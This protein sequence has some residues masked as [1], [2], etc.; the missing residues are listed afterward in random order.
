MTKA[1]EAFEKIQRLFALSDA[2]NGTRS[3]SELLQLVADSIADILPADRV[4]LIAFDR[5]SE[6]VTHFMRAG[7]G[8]EKINTSV[9]YAELLT[10][11][12]G[13]VLREGKA[14]LSPKSG[15]DPRE[16]ADVIKRRRETGCG[17]ILV[18]PL[19]HLDVNIGTITAINN[20]DQD[21]FT[22]TDRDML[23]LFADYSATVIDHAR[24]LLEVRQARISAEETSA[25]MKEYLEEKELILKEVHHRI[26]NN[27]TTIYGL[28]TMQA[29]TLTNSEAAAAL[30]DAASRVQSMMVLYNKLYE[31]PNFT[32]ISLREYIPALV[33]EIVANFPNSS[34]IRVEKDI[35]DFVLDVRRVQPLG[36]ILNEL[37]TNIMKYAFS[38]RT[39][40]RIS[41]SA[42]CM[43]GH[44]TIGVRDN[45]AGIAGASLDGTSSGFGLLLVRELTRQL[46][47]RLDIVNDGGTSVR[48]EFEK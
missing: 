24:M 9:G 6:K 25:R 4:S 41:V 36:I 14:A 18:V 1:S 2:I 44:V 35:E 48:I 45:G 22:A 47:G 17:S 12:S 28:L 31:S 29:G 42:S 5:E 23:G 37:L 27:M 43:D 7:A 10:G 26:K 33:D 19:R 8:R 39:D 40:N 13:W 30:D 32:E 15:E 16:S 38:G 11:L 46:K 3:L 21:D 34:L 20:P